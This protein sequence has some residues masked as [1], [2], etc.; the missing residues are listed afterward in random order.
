MFLKTKISQSN[1]THLSPKVNTKKD[2]GCKKFRFCFYYSVI[3]SAKNDIF[4][5]N[6]VFGG[7]LEQGIQIV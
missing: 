6:L 4:E 3:T 5:S 1:K 2:T 7:C